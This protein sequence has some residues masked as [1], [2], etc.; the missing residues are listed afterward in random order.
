[1]PERR[2]PYF[3]LGL[4]HGA[5][6]EAAQ[7]AFARLS[8]RLRRDPD[9]RYG[10]EDATWALHEIEH[11]A[12]DPSVNLGIYRVPANPAAY[13]YQAADGAGSLELPDGTDSSEDELDRLRG[14]V[15]HE[16]AAALLSELAAELVPGD[17]PEVPPEVG[18]SCPFDHAAELGIVG[19]AVAP[20]DVTAGSGCPG[21]RGW[22]GRRRRG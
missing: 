4:D 2:N 16:L 13:L 22:G 9:A 8:R 21:L 11:A 7:A 18:G 15:A 3:I 10:I 14:A 19:V 17:S 12:T 1:V 6:P 5:S 20:V